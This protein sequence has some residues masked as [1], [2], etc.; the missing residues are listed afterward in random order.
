MKKI[1]KLKI[2]GLDGYLERAIK[3]KTP[4]IT[5]ISTGRR[6]PQAPIK[7]RKKPRKPLEIENICTNWLQKIDSYNCFILN[8][9]QN[10]SNSKKAIE[11]HFWEKHWVSIKFQDFI[12]FYFNNYQ[13]PIEVAG[14]NTR[15][16]KTKCGNRFRV[17]IGEPIR[18]GIKKKKRVP[19]TYIRVVSGGAWGMG[20]KRSG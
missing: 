9:D 11:A 15:V 1:L 13:K 8:C 10:I 4:L 3:K 2:K 5:Y 16:F 19:N 12:D 7:K 14:R 6:P 18:K 17:P 20:K